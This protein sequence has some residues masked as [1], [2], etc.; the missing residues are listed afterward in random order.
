MQTVGIIGAGIMGAG[1]A[2]PVAGK[3]MAV[4]LTDITLEIAEKGKAGIATGL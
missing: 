4:V 1:I 2:Q 3:G